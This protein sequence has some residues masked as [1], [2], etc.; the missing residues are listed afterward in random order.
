[1][2]VYYEHHLKIKQNKLC[3]FKVAESH[4]SSIYP[5]PCNWHNNI[6]ILLV[7]GGSGNIQYGKNILPLEKDDIIIV[8]SGELHRPYSNIEL[9]YCFI[10]IDETFCKENGIDTAAL[11][12][13]ERFQD[14]KT[15]RLIINATERM[16]E[17]SALQE[18]LTVARLRAAMLSLI[19]D[20]ASRHSVP[21]DVK[22]EVSS[23]SEEYVKRAI[24]YIN[25]RYSERITLDD[26]ASLC[27]ITKFHL[28]R[29]FKRITGQTV[30]T[31]TNFIRCKQAEMLLSEGKNVTESAYESG[32]ES[33]SYFSRTYK[34]LMGTSP[35]KMEDN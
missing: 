17:Y 11:H 27:G 12:F 33:L 19:I 32:F 2:N 18:P 8:N 23:P 21:L 15:K 13:T 20:V 22:K 24:G 1:M 4:N 25:E 7:K 34:R 16:K 28:A 6:E 3:P 26:L 14:A 10:I 5:V 31:Y 29:E 30:F 35:S 9:S